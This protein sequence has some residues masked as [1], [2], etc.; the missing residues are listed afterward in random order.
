M[1]ANISI[2]NMSFLHKANML[3][4]LHGL[5]K[6]KAC[7]PS[8]LEFFSSRAR[9]CYKKKAIIGPRFQKT[10]CFLCKKTLLYVTLL[11]KH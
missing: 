5:P 7:P 3:S 11:Q 1:N 10:G 4:S 2:Q 6:K 9:E 8:K